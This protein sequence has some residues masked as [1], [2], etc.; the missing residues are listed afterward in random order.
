MLS[1]YDLVQRSDAELASHDIAAVNLACATGLPGAEGLDV[2]HCLAMLDAWAGHV[3]RETARC[4]GQF[5]RDP[6]AFENSRAYFRVLVLATVLQEDC[7]VR[8]D[9]TLVE[10][11][12]FFG[13]AGNLFLHG[14]LRGRGGTCS[15]LPPL[16]VAVG[17]RLG[18]P[19]RLVQTNSHLFARWD[20]PA[21]GERFNVECTSRGLNCHPDDYY[22]TWPRPT[23]PAEVERCGWLVSQT[24]RA[25]LAG[26]LV[27]R[28]HCRLDNGRH[29]QAAAC[30]AHACVLAPEHGGYRDCLRDAFDRW[31]ERL[32]R[33]APPHFPA[34]TVRLPRRR[35][36][37]LA[38]EL[39]EEL[40]RLEVVEDLLEDPVRRRDWWEPLRRCPEVRPPHLPAH[41]TVHDPAALAGRWADAPL[42]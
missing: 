23:T 17:R 39:E 12:D 11:D 41:I 28:G 4:A 38:A 42:G 29:R 10:R 21:T 22:R 33:L 5:Q 30:Y 2:G 9:P 6:P 26:F 24:P 27:S 8:Y 1:W 35:F 3:G 7:G 25:E 36:P 19:L 13:D 15:S 32:G 18:Y 40:V 31:G 20:D 34:L 16:Y 14:V 37:G